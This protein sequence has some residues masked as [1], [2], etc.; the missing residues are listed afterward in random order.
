MRRLACAML[1]GL[2]VSCLSLS[3][4]IIDM[5]DEGRASFFYSSTLE[6]GVKHKTQKTGGSSHA[7]WNYKPLAD[8]VDQL[9]GKPADAEPADETPMAEGDG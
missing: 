1:C 2:M 7:K 9:K 6:L 8:L 5:E 3:G 4:C